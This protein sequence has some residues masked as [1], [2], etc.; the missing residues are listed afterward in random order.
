MFGYEFFYSYWWVFPLTMIIF[1]IFFMR[2]GCSKMMHGCCSHAGDVSHN[3]KGESGQ[4]ILDRRF[5]QGE[6]NEDEYDEK[7]RKLAQK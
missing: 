2:R 7:K 6:I 3:S 5:A 4:E 1:C